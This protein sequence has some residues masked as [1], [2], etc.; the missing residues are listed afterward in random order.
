MERPHL[1]VVLLQILAQRNAEFTRRIESFA[2]DSIDQR[3]GRI[4]GRPVRFPPL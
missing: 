2:I 4:C 3:L 1:T